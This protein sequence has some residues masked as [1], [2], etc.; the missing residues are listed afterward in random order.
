MSS[1]KEIKP[2]ASAAPMPADNNNNHYRRGGGC[3]CHNCQ[4]FHNAAAAHLGKFKGKI[5][6]IE[7]DFFDNTGL[8]DAA[9]FNHSLKN[10]ANYLQL[11]LGNDVSEAIR[12]MMPMPIT[13]P[14]APTGQPDPKNPNTTLP[15]TDIEFYLWKQGH[16]KATKR[17]GEYDKHIAKAYIVIVQQCSLTLCNELKADKTFP[18]VCSSQDPIALL[19]LIQ[20]LCC[21]YDSKV[22]SVMAT[23]ASYKRFFTHYQRDGVD[24]HTYH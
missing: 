1:N 7:L 23:V 21:S 3:H 20:G 14:P 11:Q 13:I 22:H 4:H 2:A 6:Y 19:K 9:N 8:N 5:K 17:K 12:N 15:V 16:T 24:N 10:I 18:A